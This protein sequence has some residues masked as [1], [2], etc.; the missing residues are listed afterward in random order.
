MKRVNFRCTIFKLWDFTNWIKLRVRQFVRWH[1]NIV[2]RDKHCTWWHHL[3]WSFQILYSV[4]DFNWYITF[5]FDSAIGITL[6][7]LRIKLRKLN[8][9]WYTTYHIK[10]SDIVKN[11]NFLGISRLKIGAAQHTIFILSYCWGK[12]TG[13]WYTRYKVDFS[14]YI[15]SFS[16]NRHT[17][18]WWRQSEG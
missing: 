9:I 14:L 1:L 2:K 4:S 10:F 15:Y 8:F 11:P 6:D 3:N 18:F 16:D 17:F 13:I 5:I 12:L 7:V